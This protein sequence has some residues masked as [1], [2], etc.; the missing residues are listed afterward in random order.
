MRIMALDLAA[1]AGFCCGNAGSKPRVEAWIL[2]RDGQTI[3]A[4]CRNLAC[5]L[6][7]NIQLENPDLIVT[8]HWL[9]LQQS[10][11]AA[12]AIGQLLMHGVVDALAGIFDIKVERPETSTFRTHFCGQAS[13]A[14]RR[15]G[16]R[17]NKQRAE[18]SH[19]TNMMVVKRAILMGYLP[20]G[21]TDFD[22]ASA[23]AMW[24]WACSTYARTPPRSLVLFGERAEVGT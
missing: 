17:T 7:D 10:R 20:H 24:D 19:A 23:A 8:E 14:P 2:R 21:S 18:D 3:H 12:A 22:K 4:A 5:T 1:R 13:A 9:A 11:S 6:R 15:K 16:P